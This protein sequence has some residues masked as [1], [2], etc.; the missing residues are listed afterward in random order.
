MGIDFAVF[1]EEIA[2]QAARGL[3]SARTAGAVAEV[4][5]R[6]W[7]RAEAA[8]EL[9]LGEEARHIACRAGCGTCCVVNVGVLIPEALA[10]FHHLLEHKSE[11]GLADL[12]RCLEELERDT[13][14]LDDD[15]RIILQRP[16]VF[17]D[18]QGAC[19]IYPVRPLLCR[20]VTSTDPERCRDALCQAVFGNEAP[21]LMNLVQKN[22][23][24]SAF[25]G[26]A[27][28][29]SRVGLDAR[30][31]RLTGTVRHLLVAP[32]HAAAFLAGEQIPL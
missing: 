29:V 9:H 28:G 15:E 27:K 4:V 7:A 13:R 17:L 14:W 12:L 21:V 18:E 10:I 26:L 32:E 31:G 8:L 11:T 23:M 5:D 1:E 22:L 2:V 3:A 16:C 30:G 19:A 20:S 6:V 24:E 25:S